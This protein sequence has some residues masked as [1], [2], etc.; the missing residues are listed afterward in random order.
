MTRFSVT[1]EGHTDNVPIK[2]AQFPSNWE[3]SQCVRRSCVHFADARCPDRLTAIG[4]R[5][6]AGR[7][8]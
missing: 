1:I 6:A 8:Q 5:Y 2:T 7:T 4:W 3:L